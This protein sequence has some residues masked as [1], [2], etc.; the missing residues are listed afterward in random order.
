MHSAGKFL[1]RLIAEQI[2]HPKTGCE[3]GV[4]RGTTSSI[5]LSEFNELN[6]LMVDKYEVYKKMRCS[7]IYEIV[8][9]AV[10]RTL[11]AKDRRTILIAD[12]V[13][14]ACLIADRS[15]DFVFIDAG[16]GHQ[17]VKRDLQAWYDKVKSGGLFCGHDYYE[18]R[19]GVKRAV[20]QFAKNHRYQVNIANKHHGL[21]WFEK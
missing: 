14:A 20:D 2:G 6:L 10:E 11:F 19:F 12:S 3:V 1:S 9:E 8:E 4:F 17:S 16:H 7:S 18:H 21:W 15:L 13:R 5:L